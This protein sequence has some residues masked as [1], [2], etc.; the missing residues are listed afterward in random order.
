MA[1]IIQPES[2]ASISGAATSYNGLLDSGERLHLSEYGVK[3]DPTLERTPQ[4]RSPHKFHSETILAHFVGILSP[5]ARY[6]SIFGHFTLLFRLLALE[7]FI[8]KALDVPPFAQILLGIVAAA[9][10]F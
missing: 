8:G 2:V 5:G 3:Q 1:N 10:I 9:N 4:N 6:S 7:E